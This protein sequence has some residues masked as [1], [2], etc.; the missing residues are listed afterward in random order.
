M[1]LNS[2]NIPLRALLCVGLLLSAPLLLQA[3]EAGM[4]EE[5]GEQVTKRE[6]SSDERGKLFREGNYAL[7]IHWGLYSQL[8]NRYNGKTYYGIGEW[9]KNRRMADIPVA[10]YRDLAQDFNPTEFDARA[11]AQLAKDAGMRYIVITAKHHE[12][13]AMFD[14][15]ADD[16]NIVDMTPYGKDPM[17]E[18]AKAC[19]AVGIGFGFY[20]SHHIDWIA[21][22]ARGGPKLHLDGTEATYEDYFYGKSLPQLKELTTNYGPLDILWFDLGGSI[23]RTYAEELLEVVRTNQ[24]GAMVNGRL[25]HGLGDYK[26]LGD[27]DVPRGNVE[28]LWETVDTTNDSWAYAWYDENWK[29]PHQILTRLISTVGRGGTYMLNIG[30]RGDGSVPIPA[31]KALRAAGQWLERYPAVVYDAGAS[32]WGHALPWGDVTVQGNRLLLSVYTMPEDRVLY[33]PGLETTIRSV[34]LL[35]PDAGDSSKALSLS[36]GGSN[37][38]TKI[39]LPAVIEEPLIPVVEIEL[40]GTPEVTPTPGLDPSVKTT[41]LTE[42]AEVKGATIKQKGWMEKFGE[43]KHVYRAFEWEPDGRASWQVEVLEP[44]YYQVDLTYAGKGRLAW[45]VGIDGGGF[46]QNQQNASHNYQEFPIGWL[47]FP[48]PGRYTV[49]VSCVE[50]DLEAASLKAAQFK[51]INL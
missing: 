45:R 26:S 43:W 40:A 20:Y 23:K 8:A 10:E 38:W 7:F 51:K 9:M 41:L 27:M 49:Y 29:P 42:F 48:E 21:P 36:Y 39:Q 17:L 33:L 32:P 4:D 37:G 13:F 18:L 34:K 30:P 14:S 3:A 47:E 11:I 19:R 46:I 1:K 50:G 16:F 31:Q 22:G 2:F 44:G 15:E 6:L 28:G 5:W 24:P 12:G 35:H 25:G